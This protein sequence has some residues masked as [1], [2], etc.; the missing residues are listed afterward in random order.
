MFFPFPP[1]LFPAI[2]QYVFP[3]L[4]CVSVVDIPA[5]RRTVAYC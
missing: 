2:R 3:F 4:G 5:N 1:G